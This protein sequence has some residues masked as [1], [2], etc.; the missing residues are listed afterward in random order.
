M[1]IDSERR[2]LYATARVCNGHLGHSVW[3]PRRGQRLWIS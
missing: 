2:M 3:R 1:L